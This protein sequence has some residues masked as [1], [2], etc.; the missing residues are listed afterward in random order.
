MFLILINMSIILN[1][2]NK[3]N[4][5]DNTNQSTEI[6][7]TGIGSTEAQSTEINSTEAQSTE[8]SSTEAQS[9]EV[10]STEA[11]STEI[12][13]TNTSIDSTT[14]DSTKTTN[15][16]EYEQIIPNKLVIG[17]D[18]YKHS[19]DILSFYTY[20]RYYLVRPYSRIV[21]LVNII[22]NLRALDEFN[23]NINCNYNRSN[24]NGDE[25][26]S[27]YKCEENVTGTISK[28]EVTNIVNLTQSPLAIS[29]GK[30]LN[31]QEGDKISDQGLVV[32]KDCKIIISP[33]G[34]ITI[35]GTSDAQLDQEDL[36]LYVIQNDGSYV[37]VPAT[38]STGNNSEINIIFTPTK[39]IHSNLQGVIGKL[40]GGKNIYLNFTNEDSAELDYPIGYSW[41]KN[42][43]TSSGL[44]A[45]GIVG[46]IIPCILV[47][48]V[49]AGLVFFLGRKPPILPT[50]NIGNTIG[51]T[52]S[53]DIVI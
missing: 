30:D 5:Q 2:T 41:N 12:N 38:L 9:T 15:S 19:S 11:Q 18:N 27:V 29:M 8:V 17:Y 16:T 46:I 53:S 36:I 23:Q 47:L 14:T 35:K 25:I 44:S 34:I 50:Q 42:K 37:E 4:L 1:L 39:S 43:K 33:N 51:V 52:S 7:S 28:V 31:K 49:T 40:E 24:T 10:S 22:R 48:A 6:S 26:I 45:G 3:R 20:V 13:S 32:I 21:I